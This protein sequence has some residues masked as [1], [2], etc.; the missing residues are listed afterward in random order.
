MPINELLSYLALLM[1]YH[2]V[3]GLYVSVHDALAMAEVQCLCT[4]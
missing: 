3:V 1:I 2:H 4:L